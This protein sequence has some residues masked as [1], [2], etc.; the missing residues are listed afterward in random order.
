MLIVLN[1]GMHLHTIRPKNEEGR[2]SRVNFVRSLSFVVAFSDLCVVVS[3]DSSI[4]FQFDL[5]ARK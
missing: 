3:R 1:G 5:V 2:K 4:L